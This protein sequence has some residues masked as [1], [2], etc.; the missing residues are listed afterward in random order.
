MN[1]NPDLAGLRDAA[2]IAQDALD[3][4]RER[5]EDIQPAPSPAL[6]KA[7][8]D[9]GKIAT[10]LWIDSAKLEALKIIAL[11]KRV[12]FNDLILQ[13]IE[14]VIALNEELAA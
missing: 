6:A 7:K 3:Q 2:E 14:H 10:L 8:A 4:Y 13:G 11:R 9:E 1:D 12:C 5:I